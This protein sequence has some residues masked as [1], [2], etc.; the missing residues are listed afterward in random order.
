MYP[1][2]FNPWSQ[3]KLAGLLCMSILLLQV[4]ETACSKASLRDQAQ[5]QESS[6]VSQAQGTHHLEKARS[7]FDSGHNS[8]AQAEFLSAL[9][10]NPLQYAAHL[11]LADVYELQGDAVAALAEYVAHTETVPKAALRVERMDAYA[12][13]KFRQYQ[14][15]DRERENGYKA[16]AML[17]LSEAVN[18]Y[19]QG[20][21]DA[22]LGMTARS[23][24][25]LPEFGMLDYLEGQ[26]HWQMDRLPQALSA[27]LKA[28]RSNSFLAARLLDRDLG[29]RLPDLPGQ[30]ERVLRQVL[31]HHPADVFA[32]IQ[33]AALSYRQGQY[34]RATKVISQ[35]LAWT[36]PRWELSVIEAA[37]HWHLAQKEQMARSLAVID[38]ARI[39]LSLAFQAHQPSLFR[40]VL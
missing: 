16:R 37:A 12:R 19:R 29:S 1:K 2:R 13:A 18:L 39:D 31:A 36:E 27:W 8:L 33:L 6:T 34:R 35:A 5:E 28:A 3:G 15:Q 22:A 32:S 4:A 20:K 7:F 11:G 10:A 24:A 14:L 25:L 21:Y 9:R 26:V 40:G 38:R 23:K 17:F 30:M